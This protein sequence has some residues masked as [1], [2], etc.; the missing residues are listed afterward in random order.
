MEKIIVP[1][2]AIKCH[3]ETLGEAL[4]GYLKYLSEGKVLTWREKGK[5]KQY[6]ATTPCCKGYWKWV[7]EEFKGNHIL[8]ASPMELI[9]FAKKNDQE[10]KRV[11]RPCSKS[12]EL[13]DEILKGIDKLSL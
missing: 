2:K 5:E 8:T 12:K 4:L 13:Q 11:G 1:Q 6:Q 9:R 7:Y 3:E 10:V